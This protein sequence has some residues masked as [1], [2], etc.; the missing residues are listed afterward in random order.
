MKKIGS[1]E[2]AESKFCSVIKYENIYGCQFHPERSGVDG[3]IFLKEF[4]KNLDEK[5]I[6]IDTQYETLPKG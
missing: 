5:N 4:Y 2:Y 3:E 6:T 1:T